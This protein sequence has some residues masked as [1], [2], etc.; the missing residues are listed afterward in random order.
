[1]T[2]AVLKTVYKNAYVQNF[3]TS[4]IFVLL[5][6]LDVKVCC[7]WVRSGQILLEE[8]FYTRMATDKKKLHK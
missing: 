8:I 2:N 1:M 4:V 3:Q 6:V 7:D 5:T